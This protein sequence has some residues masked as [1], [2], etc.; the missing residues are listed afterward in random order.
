MKTLRNIYVSLDIKIIIT[1]DT[2]LLDHWKEGSDIRVNDGGSRTAEDT[3]LY[4]SPHL[5]IY[6]YA[7]VQLPLFPTIQN[8]RLSTSR[9]Q[10]ATDADGVL[11]FTRSG[12]D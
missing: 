8:V 6:F 9:S 11:T 4:T 12:A 7:W 2:S 10:W 5:T 3:D 1:S